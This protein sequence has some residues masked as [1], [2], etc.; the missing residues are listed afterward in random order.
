MRKELQATVPRIGQEI[1]DNLTGEEEQP[2]VWDEEDQPDE[3]RKNKARI[4]Y[5]VTVYGKIDEG[6]TDTEDERA[7]E[8]PYSIELFIKHYTYKEHYEQD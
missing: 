5:L 4:Q 8:C 3:T 7:N 1:S 6:V 2:F